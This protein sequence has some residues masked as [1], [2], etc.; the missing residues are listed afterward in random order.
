MGQGFFQIGVTL[1]IVIAITPLLGRYIARVFLEEK[2]LLDP[3][4]KP[5]E[6][7]IFT[8]AGTRTK[9]EMT[10]WQ[11]ARAVLYSNI[12]M[13]VVVFLLISFQKFLPWNPLG[14]AAPKWDITLHTT[15][16]FLTN[17]DQQHYS[18]ETTLSYFSQTD[19]KSVV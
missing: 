14:F 5:V 9:D 7:I 19:R 2:T 10:G 1:C 15:I 13:G 11:Y 18:G 4:M 17:T 3:V 16:S 8:L 6:R 12:I